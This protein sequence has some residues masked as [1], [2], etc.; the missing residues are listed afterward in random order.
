MLPHSL[1]IARYADETESVHFGKRT[2]LAGTSPRGINEFVETYI[3]FI[4]LSIPLSF[5]EFQGTIILSSNLPGSHEFPAHIKVIIQG[6]SC[7]SLQPA[8]SCQITC[9]QGDIGVDGMLAFIVY[10]FRG[11]KI[12]QSFLTSTKRVEDLIF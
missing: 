12:H 4:F 11:L 5:S 8:E 9:G 6:S 10:T 7:Q 3:S 1:I 2:W